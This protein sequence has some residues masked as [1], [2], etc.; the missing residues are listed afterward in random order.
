MKK[1]SFLFA[2]LVICLPFKVV[3][4]D[5]QDFKFNT[6]KDLYDLCSENRTSSD[7]APA[8]Y[9]CRAFIEAAV[10]YHDAVSDGENLKRLICYGP[11]ATIADG[12]KAFVDWVD[13]NINDKKLMGE[14]PVIGL[15][16]ALAN[17]YP[18]TK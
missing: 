8:I 6:T 1:I 12:R 11:D 16:R 2:I 3:A 10:Q 4:I 9:A 5:E 14:I 7:Y 18:C 15:V 17:K 13:R